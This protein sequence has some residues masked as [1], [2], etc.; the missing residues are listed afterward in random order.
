MAWR[1]KR[2]LSSPRSN[3]G[4]TMFQLSGAFSRLHAGPCLRDEVPGFVAEQ[5]FYRRR[6]KGSETRG[7]DVL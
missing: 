2:Y 3:P 5:V 7:G 4:E 6:G 1:A